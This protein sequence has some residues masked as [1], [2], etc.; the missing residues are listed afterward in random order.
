MV[1]FCHLHSGGRHHTGLPYELSKGLIFIGLH[2]LKNYV[3]SK[4]LKV[5]KIYYV[6]VFIFAFCLNICLSNHAFSTGT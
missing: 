4:V 1:D 5:K 3:D 2:K 6:H